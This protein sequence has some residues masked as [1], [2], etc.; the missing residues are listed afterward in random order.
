MP[1]HTSRIYGTDRRLART[2]RSAELRADIA[3]GDQLPPAE[4]ISQVFHVALR[5]SKIRITIT[6]ATAAQGGTAAAASNDGG[7]REAGFWTT[8]R[9]IGAA[10]VGLAAIVTAVAAV[11]ALHLKF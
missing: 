10:I 7:P 8:S 11:V 1:R 6:N 5:G 2:E 4:R 9:R 3:D